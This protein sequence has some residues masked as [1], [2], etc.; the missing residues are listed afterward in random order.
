MGVANFQFS[1]ESMLSMD[2][3]YLQGSPM[4]LGDE[5]KDHSVVYGALMDIL[6]PSPHIRL[7]DKYKF[8]VILRLIDLADLWSIEKVYRVIIEYTRYNP[9]YRNF[10]LFLIAIKL[11]DYGLAASIIERDDKDTV[12]E[13]MGS[14]IFP[15]LQTYGDSAIGS[16]KPFKS[17]EAPAICREENPKRRCIRTEVTRT[18]LYDIKSCEYLDFIQLPPQVAWALQRATLMWDH[19]LTDSRV[20]LHSASNGERIQKRKK[21]IAENF[22][23]IKIPNRKLFWT[24]T[25]AFS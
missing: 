12:M 22:K 23:R 15:P 24:C 2:P 21:A 13:R 3:N 8:N 7:L 10:D 9:R 1:L 16:I 6:Y 5:L 25:P 20:L 14:D 19:G 11:K 18:R 17:K 4:E